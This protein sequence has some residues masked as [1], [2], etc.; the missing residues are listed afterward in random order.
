MRP[1]KTISAALVV[2][3]FIAPSAGAD[4]LE[5]SSLA[6]MAAPLEHSSRVYRDAAQLLYVQAAEDIY[7]RLS[8][9]DQPDAQSFILYSDNA[10][11]K[12]NPMHLE[13]AGL[14][15]IVHPDEHGRK[16]EKGI[17]FPIYADG[18]AP[19]VKAKL[20][21]APAHTHKQ[22]TYFGHGL[23]GTLSA[24]DDV[25]GVQ[26]T[27]VSIDGQGFTPYVDQVRFDQEKRYSFRHY[28]V[29]NVGNASNPGEHT[30]V[31][32]L[33]PPETTNVVLHRHEGQVLSPTASLELTSRDNQS[34]VGVK[35]V[36]YSFDGSDESLEYEGAPVSVDGLSEGEHKLTFGAEDWVKNR[37]QVK[38]FQFYIDRTP[39]EVS[40]SVVGDQSR[41]GTT[42]Y[43]SS[44]SRVK[45]EATD[46]KTGV[47]RIEYD[48]N[49]PDVLVYVEPFPLPPKSGMMEIEFR[50]QDEM[51]NVS[52]KKTLQLYLDLEPPR[53]DHR[54][55]GPVFQSQSTTFVTSATEIELVGSDREAGLRE[56]QFILDDNA[57]KIYQKPFT[58]EKDG[59]HVVSHYG[60]DNVNNRGGNQSVAFVVDNVPPIISHHFGTSPIGKKG[61]LEEYPSH[62]VLFLAATDQLSGLDEIFY[63]INGGEEK[64][65]KS[66]ILFREQGE[67][68]VNVRVRDKV[69]NEISG[70]VRLAIE[71]KK[72]AKLSQ[73]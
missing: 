68:T 43:V 45:L 60:L 19:S 46:N 56:I 63:S 71:R 59:A 51:A 40:A 66:P 42:R 49:S 48:V 18:Q 12:T 50:A 2:A 25:S 13:G 29:D 11:E 5:P 37:E 3:F 72:T 26:Q 24:M 41:T 67:I 47:E 73:N 6:R 62:T 64:L 38:E 70:Q 31:V 54:F 39:P 1:W 52:A 33:S 44:R 69:N 36:F 32:D 15:T 7:L 35:H 58:L 14:H 21:G 10:P 16:D 17:V 57:P 30:F 4:D 22:V 23:V 61:G 27:L 55:S 20:R 34:G 53:S 8:T 28:A 9:S 65:Y